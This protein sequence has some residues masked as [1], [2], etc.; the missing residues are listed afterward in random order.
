[1]GIRRYEAP[2]TIEEAV[3]LLTAEPGAA[4]ILAGGTDMV[5]DVRAGETFTPANVRSIRPGMG[6]AP[7]LLPE[8]LG[9]RAAVNIARGA[10]MTW[11]MVAGRTDDQTP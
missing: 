11:D 5:A 9:R 3:G 2:K 1:M 6:L 7:S 10:P 8:V 4:S